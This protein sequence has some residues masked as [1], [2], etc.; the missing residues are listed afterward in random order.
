MVTHDEAV[1]QPETSIF[2]FK[3]NQERDGEKTPL[4]N[5]NIR[6]AIAKSFQKEDLADVVLANGSVPANYIVPQEFAYDE[7]GTDFRDISGDHLV[8]DAEEA[9]EYWQ[10]G[11]DELG[12]TEVE[13]EILGGD[14]D[15]SKKMSE[16]F[17][18]QLETNLEGLTI[19]LKEVP[20]SVRLELDTNQDYDIQV[21]GWGPD[22]Q[23]PISF[24]DLFVTNG[25]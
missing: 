10:K 15:L 18:S 4:A 23:D 19:K 21:S 2:Y 8:Y 12:V 3:F 16:Y 24:M 7:N 20:F 5:V 9:K 13:L 25:H 22:F 17:K 14:T 11:L 1:H 6:K